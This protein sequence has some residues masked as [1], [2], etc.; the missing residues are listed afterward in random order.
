MG[1]VNLAR[2][3]RALRGATRAGVDTAVW[4]YHLEDVRPYSELTVHLLAE[5][6][7]GRLELIL[8][9]VTLAEILAG[10]WRTGDAERAGRIE[11][12]LEALPGVRP[13][14]ATWAVASAAARIRGELKLPLPDAFIIASA[15]DQQAQLLVTNDATWSRAASLGARV[16]LLDQGEG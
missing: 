5:A 10:P 7:A 15:L 11:A 4:I 9:T 13:A 6:A 12:V 3:A 1:E 8:S 2:F 16:V 14:A